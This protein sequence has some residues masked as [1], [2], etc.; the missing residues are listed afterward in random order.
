MSSMDSKADFTAMMTELQVPDKAQEWLLAQG[1]STISDL[2]FTFVN[3]ADGAALLSKLPEK[4]WT[5]MGVDLATEEYSTTVPAGKLRRLLAQCRMMVQ[6]FSTSTTAAATSTSLSPVAT[7]VWQEL[8]PPRLTPEAVNQM[9]ETFQTNFP[10]ELLTSETTPSI[11][12]L[13]VVHHY[14]KPG[15]AI[16]YTPWQIRMSQ[17]QYQDMTEAKTHKPI[18][19]EAQLLGA[20]L[21]ETPEIPLENM[22][23]SAEWL[24]KTQQVFRNAWVMVGAAHL[25]IFKKFDDKFFGLAMKRH[26]PESMLRSVNLAELLEA[27]KFLWGEIS[28]LLSKKWS[29]NDALNEL[30][31]ARADIYGVL[32]PRPRASPYK[33]GTTTPPTKQPR[34]SATPTKKTKVKQSAWKDKAADLATFMF[35]NGEKKILCQRYQRGNCTSKSCKFTRACAFKV[36]G[37]P[38]GKNHGAHAHG[39]QT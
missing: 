24:M 23:L 27:D 25:Q 11:R 14:M 33:P 38:C 15:Q 13:S 9:I 29:L 2:A 32:Q 22:K 4:L 30:T 39:T 12:L 31:S 20:L 35:A 18:R 21:D 36:Q 8:A 17:K 3:S 37:R 7:P 5:D 6:Q 10:G 16:K 26:S 19:S 1:F 28:S 34:D